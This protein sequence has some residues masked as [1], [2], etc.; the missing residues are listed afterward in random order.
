MSAN[1]YEKLNA[2]DLVR[3]Y[4]ELLYAA[5]DPG[6]ADKRTHA[7]AHLD[8]LVEIRW[9]RAVLDHIYSRMRKEPVEWRQLLKEL[10]EIKDRIRRDA[11]SANQRSRES[12]V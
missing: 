11:K 5:R 3:D 1:E 10:G 4:H 8:S 12:D 6:F 2:C 9:L 7:V